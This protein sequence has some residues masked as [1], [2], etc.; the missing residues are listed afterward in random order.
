MRT[1]KH[2]KTREWIST[3]VQIYIVH[4]FK[5][6]YYLHTYYIHIFIRIYTHAK[7]HE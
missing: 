1:Y 4:T 2:T 5:N 3:S 7:I 6:T